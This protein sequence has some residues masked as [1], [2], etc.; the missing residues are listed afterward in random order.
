MLSKLFPQLLQALDK[1]LPKGLAVQLLC[2]TVKHPVGD[3]GIQPQCQAQ[4][5]IGSN[6]HRLATIVL[7]PVFLVGEVLLLQPAGGKLAVASPG[8]AVF[9]C[10]AHRFR[11]LAAAHRLLQ[12]QF[13]HDAAPQAHLTSGL[14]LHLMPSHDEGEV[15]GR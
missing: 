14:Q 7:L 3:D 1:R 5:A 4:V 12:H 13:I 15:G 9:Q 6:V 11:I 10:P 8:F 2:S